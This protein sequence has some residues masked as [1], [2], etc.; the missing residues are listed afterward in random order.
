MIDSLSA[1]GR[2]T[3]AWLGS[4]PFLQR[5]IREQGLVLIRTNFLHHVQAEEAGQHNNSHHAARL[6]AQLPV[7]LNE[8]RLECEDGGLVFFITSRLTAYRRVWAED[9][10]PAAV[11]FSAPVLPAAGRW[12]ARNISPHITVS[13]RGTLSIENA[14]WW[15]K[16][17][18]RKVDQVHIPTPEVPFPWLNPAP[19]LSERTRWLKEMTHLHH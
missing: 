13:H 7:R 15:F 6:A 4:S 19:W 2:S 9:I 18:A 10:H 5:P 12:S 16:T 3:G 14:S 8:V 17:I 1:W 11:W